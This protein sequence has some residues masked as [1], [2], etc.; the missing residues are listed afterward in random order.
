MFNAIIGLAIKISRNFSIKRSSYIDL[1]KFLK[2]KKSIIYAQNNDNK[3]FPYTGLTSI[4]VTNRTNKN[5]PERVSKYKE[6]DN[7]LNFDGIEF[8]VSIKSINKF[9]KQNKNININIFYFENS[10]IRPFSILKINPQKGIDLIWIEKDK[11]QNYCWIK[12][13]SNSC[14]NQFIRQDILNKHVG[15]CLDKEAVK[16]ITL[17]SN[18]SLQE[19][20]HVIKTP[21]KVIYKNIRYEPILFVTM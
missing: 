14:L 6:C 1:P 11:K 13:F 18:V 10:S 20:Q 2:D 21:L 5:I 17:T 8:P 19:F 15:C 3:C 16:T 4:F 7:Y 9:E 12:N